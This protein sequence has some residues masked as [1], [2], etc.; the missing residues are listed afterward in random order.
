MSYKSTI[1]KLEPNAIYAIDQILL[2][3]PTIDHEKLHHLL[4]LRFSKLM[5]LVNN[6]TNSI[7]QPFNLTQLT[8]V[9]KVDISYR[10]IN[11]S[12][13]IQLTILQLT[14]N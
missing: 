5:R 1:L 10:Y 14:F 6:N 11:N 4:F 12:G 3:I 8:N 2:R 9:S 7:T 13:I